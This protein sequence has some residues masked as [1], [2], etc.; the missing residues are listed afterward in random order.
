MSLHCIVWCCM[1]LYCW[2]WRASCISQDTYLLYHYSYGRHT[3]ITVYLVDVP[4]IVQYSC[5]LN[6]L[7]SI[8]SC[9]WRDKDAK[10][11]IV[12]N[13]LRGFKKEALPALFYWAGTTKSAFDRILSFFHSLSYFAHQS[14]TISCNQYRFYSSVHSAERQI[15]LYISFL[16]IIWT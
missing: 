14:T 1:V 10:L 8:V 12:W 4:H 2:L 16:V 9:C 3:C 5:V 6:R 13:F 11:V 7:V 15:C